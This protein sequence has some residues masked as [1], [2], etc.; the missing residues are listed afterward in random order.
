MKKIPKHHSTLPLNSSPFLKNIHNLLRL[1]GTLAKRVEGDVVAVVGTMTKWM[2]VVAWV[3]VEWVTV[4][5]AE[6][7]SVPQGVLRRIQADGRA[8]EGKG[9]S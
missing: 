2:G 3:M 1:G 7:V 5:A 6:F 4:R 9:H 8:G